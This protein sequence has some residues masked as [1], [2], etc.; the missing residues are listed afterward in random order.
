MSDHSI[1]IRYTHSFKWNH[2]I[3]L[4]FDAWSLHIP[5]NNDLLLIGT[6]ANGII[7]IKLPPANS[8]SGPIIAS[9]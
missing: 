8:I 7:Q 2:C 6:P 3:T 1:Y 9:S 4:P 5:E